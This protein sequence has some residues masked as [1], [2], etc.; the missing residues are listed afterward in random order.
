MNN[1]TFGFIGAGRITRILL[2]GFLRAALTRLILIVD[3]YWL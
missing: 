1:R 2:E 3:L